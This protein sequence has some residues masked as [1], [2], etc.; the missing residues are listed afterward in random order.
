M[1]LYANEFA[2]INPLVLYSSE[3]RAV[4]FMYVSYVCVRFV[5]AFV[6]ATSFRSYLIVYS[7][8][9]V[10]MF[11]CVSNSMKSTAKWVTAITFDG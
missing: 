8:Y 7:K 1:T 2:L 6:V 11:A 10:M 4:S 5:V 9:N 3:S